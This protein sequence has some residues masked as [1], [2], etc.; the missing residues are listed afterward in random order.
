MYDYDMDDK[1]L[2]KRPT[3]TIEE[4]LEE[5]KKRYPAVINEDVLN[6]IQ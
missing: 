4:W 5:L 3:H 2:A 6:T 1:D